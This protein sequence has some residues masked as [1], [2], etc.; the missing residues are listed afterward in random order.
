MLC[1]NLQ[2]AGL[3]LNYDQKKLLKKN[4]ATNICM[5]NARLTKQSFSALI[6]ANRRVNMLSNLISDPAGV[7]VGLVCFLI[8]ISIY[9]FAM[10]SVNK[11]R[12]KW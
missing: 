10:L 4:E 2:P 12:K 1:F 9:G 6:T 8:A 11:K 3:M 5:Q 7:A